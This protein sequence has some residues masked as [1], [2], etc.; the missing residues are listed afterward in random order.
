ML[1]SSGHRSTVRDRPTILR[2]RMI[3]IRSC[4]LLEPRPHADRIYADAK[5]VCR[6]K[7]KLQ[8][9]QSNCTDN[10][11]VDDC[12][13]ESNPRFSCEQYCRQHSEETRKI[14]QMKHRALNLFSRQVDLNQTA[15]SSHCEAGRSLRSFKGLLSKMEHLVTPCGQCCR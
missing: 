3:S 1:Q 14:V 6:N 11:A 4:L 15:L 2:R 8:R 10:Q 9:S 5:Q 7:A 12:D 13:K